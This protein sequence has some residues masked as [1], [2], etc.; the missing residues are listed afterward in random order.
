VLENYYGGPVLTGA[1]FDGTLTSDAWRHLS[2]TVITYTMNP[3]WTF[4]LN[5][6]AGAVVISPKN[7]TWWGLAGYAKYTFSPKT[8]FALRYEYYDDPQ[9]Y[10]GVLFGAPGFA[11]EVTGTYSYNLTSGLLVRG[12]YRYDFAQQPIFQNGPVNFVKEQN[13]LY[14][15]FVYSFSSANLK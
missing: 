7:L 8:N 12:E 6:D 15:S 11:Q 4:S 1:N 13:T 9:G 3:K 10:T 5:G 2:D 14:L